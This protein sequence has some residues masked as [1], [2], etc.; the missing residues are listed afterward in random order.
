MAF[1]ITAGILLVFLVCVGCSR[2]A[3][4]H[5][6]A[7]EIQLV[8]VQTALRLE[9]YWTQEAF[10][11]R[12]ASIMDDVHG[13]ITDGIPT[14]VVFP[15]DIGLSLVLQGMENQLQRVSSMADGIQ[16]VTK[17]HLVPAFWQRFRS[18]LSWVPALFL[19]RHRLI[20]NAYFSTFSQLAKGHGVYILAGSAILPPYAI[21]GG[22]VHWQRPLK[23]AVHNS[24]YL[25]GPDG[26]V[27]GRQDKVHLIDLEQAAA[28]D[29]TPGR[30]DDLQ[31]FETHLGRLGTAICLDAFQDDVVTTLDHRGAQILLQ[32][33]ANPGPWDRIQQEDWLNSSHRQV[34]QRGLFTYGVN[35]ML[36]G[37]LWDV[38]FFGQSSIVGSSAVPT[39]AG[40]YS[41]TP[42]VSGFIRTAASDRQPEI[43][44]ARLPHPD[45]LCRQ[46]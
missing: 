4:A 13:Q 17:A 42:P 9:D 19:H 25:F 7:A 8:A 46:A 3:S 39:T 43:L 26:S 33:S 11:A 24:A 45:V 35:P 5:E 31:V 6:P 16:K 2:P 36:H 32:P 23:A 15:E 21:N 12:L 10:A 44:V 38:S 41:D 30:L 20:A 34:C 22:E 14:L 1:L 37:S 40:G 29:L 18:R 28:L 27:I